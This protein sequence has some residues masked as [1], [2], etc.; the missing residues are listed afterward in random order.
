MR[1]LAAYMSIPYVFISFADNYYLYFTESTNVALNK[2]AFLSTLYRFGNASMAV[3]GNEDG[4]WWNG[5]C[6]HT[7]W[8]VRPW[9]AVDLGLKTSVFAVEITNRLDDVPGTA[10]YVRSD[11]EYCK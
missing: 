9:W 5:S 8:E 7:D 11:C 6:A 3:D 10:D 4:V 1:I 2:P